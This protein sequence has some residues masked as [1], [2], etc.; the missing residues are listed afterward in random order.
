M[1]N[2]YDDFEKRYTDKW[3]SAGWVEVNSLVENKQILHRNI[4]HKNIET[5]EDELEMINQTLDDVSMKQ[6]RLA[7]LARFYNS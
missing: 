1:S 2:M 4:E 6:I 3:F 5:L 7:N